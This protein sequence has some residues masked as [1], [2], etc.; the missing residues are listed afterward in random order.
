MLGHKST[1]KPSPSA[2]VRQQWDGAG[3]HEEEYRAYG[4][5]YATGG[6]RVAQLSE[7]IELMHTV[8]T[9]SAAT[10]DGRWYH[11][12][13]A[14]LIPKPD[15]PIPIMV[16]TKEPLIIAPSGRRAGWGG[17]SGRLRGR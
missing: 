15:P 3:W 6:L 11:T 12:E 2:D 16:G 10:H 1:Q 13:G 7:A 9:E 4:F 8:W 14:T 5:D 17:R